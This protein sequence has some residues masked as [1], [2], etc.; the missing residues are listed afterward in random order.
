MVNSEN[1]TLDPRDGQGRQAPFR[2][3]WENLWVSTATSAVALANWAKTIYSIVLDVLRRI[4][5]SGLERRRLRVIHAAYTLRKS[6]KRWNTLRCLSDEKKEAWRSAFLRYERDYRYGSTLAYRSEGIAGAF[7]VL[8]FFAAVMAV[9]SFVRIGSIRLADTGLWLRF[10]SLY[11]YFGLLLAFCYPF[12]LV[13]RL[14]G[15]RRELLDFSLHSLLLTS[16]LI[17]MAAFVLFRYQ[18]THMHGFAA[19]LLGFAIIT[20]AVPVYFLLALAPGLSWAAIANRI[21]LY[22]HWHAHIVHELFEAIKDLEQF[23]GCA[24]VGKRARVSKRLDRI[25][26]LIGKGLLVQFQTRDPVTQT[27]IDQRARRM[28]NAFRDKR[29]WLITPKADTIDHLTEA[30]AGALV[31]LLRGAW[32]ELELAEDAPITSRAIVTVFLAGLRAVILAALPLAMFIAAR[33][34][35]WLP[36]L[37]TETSNYIELG[38]FVWAV[39]SL[40]LIVDP[41][42]K[43]KIELM[44][45]VRSLVSRGKKESS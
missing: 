34:W 8:L 10:I 23:E 39:L 40:L 25:A 15:R 36:D 21:A 3:A 35:T 28:A 6:A 45:S 1:P 2:K 18:Q 26:A 20:A 30:L 7:V 16:T 44:N 41:A 37:S 13:D 5:R 43:E 27:W 38:L 32:D 22:Q 9:P 24:D 4:D 31:S 17:G 14:F 11:A 33:R 12:W 42:L 29:K 19:S